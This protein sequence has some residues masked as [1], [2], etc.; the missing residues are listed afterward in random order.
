MYTVVTELCSFFLDLCAK[1][2]RV[3]DLDRLQTYIIVI[4][5]KL[6]R[7]FPPA[8]FSIMVHLIVHYHMKP[9]LMVQFL[10]YFIEFKGDCH[11]IFKK[12]DSEQ[13]RTNPSHILVGRLEN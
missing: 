8:L 3:S 1:M 5:C 6:E 4:L 13:A 12:Y 9:R 11:K 7:I 2:I 10:T